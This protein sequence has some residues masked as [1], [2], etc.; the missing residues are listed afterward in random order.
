M[1]DCEIMPAVGDH[2]VSEQHRPTLFKSKR[3]FLQKLTERHDALMLHMR[4]SKSEESDLDDQLAPSRTSSAS[5]SQKDFFK[6]SPVTWPS[7][8]SVSAKTDFA[9]RYDDSAIDTSLPSPI[10]LRSP[11]STCD[12]DQWTVPS[13]N[14][15]PR[16]HSSHS[17]TSSA[18]SC[19]SPRTPSSLSPIRT[20][21]IPSQMSDAQIDAWLEDPEDADAHRKRKSC[22]PATYS[23]VL[24]ERTACRRKD[25]AR[26]MCTSQSAAESKPFSDPFARSRRRMASV[27]GVESVGV[28]MAGMP[29]EVLLGIAKH[30][31]AGDVRAARGTC[32]RLYV[33]VPEPVVVGKT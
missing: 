16:L 11:L 19:V 23:P 14:D 3:S 30:L 18:S 17:T 13:L 5:S 20:R 27:I 2:F 29:M 15:I 26:T 4:I 21:S 10:M 6:L 33:A 24:S 8:S 12:F 1:T 9:M 25:V 28:T 22:M 32:R 7:K 31:D